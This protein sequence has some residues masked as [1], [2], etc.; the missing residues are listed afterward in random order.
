MALCSRCH[1]ELNQSL[2]YCIHCGAIRKGEAASES[3]QKSSN[4]F[5]SLISRKRSRTYFEIGWRIFKQDK[6]KFIGYAALADFLSWIGRSIF[7]GSGRLIVFFLKR[8]FSHFEQQFIHG[9]PSLFSS[10]AEIGMALVLAILLLILLFCLFSLD[11]SLLVGFHAAA[12][13]IIRNQQVKFRDFWKGFHFFVPLGFVTVAG[14]IILFLPAFAGGVIFWILHLLRISLLPPVLF[15]SL[16]IVAILFYIVYFIYFA[17]VFAFAPLFVLDKNPGAFNALKM[18]YR[19]IK[20]NWRTVSDIVFMPAVLLVMIL[21]ISFLLLAA[22][23][24]ILSHFFAF[25]AFLRILA[26]FLTIAFFSILIFGFSLIVIP[27]GLCCLTAAY[28]DLSGLT[29]LDFSFQPGSI[30][31]T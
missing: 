21:I 3:A 31:T 13:R 18:S 12:F 23:F 30:S 15:T 19:V 11:I 29:P 7:N 6:W 22:G 14:F 17:V 9:F 10:L 2:P 25:M 24:F 27:Y 8:I 16:L 4:L 5:F 20:K 1:Q 26:V 28:G